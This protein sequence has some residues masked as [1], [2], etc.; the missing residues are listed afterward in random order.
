MICVSPVRRRWLVQL[1]VNGDTEKFPEN[2]TVRDILTAMTLREEIVLVFLNG[3]M[4]KPETWDA[5]TV[6]PEDR[7]EIIKVV[8]GG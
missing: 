4:V 6:S 1:K 3:E 7:L 8:G 2:S 5:V